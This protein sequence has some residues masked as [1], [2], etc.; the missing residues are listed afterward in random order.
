[1][2]KCEKCGKTDFDMPNGCQAPSVYSPAVGDWSCIV[3]RSKAQLQP[4]WHSPETAPRDKPFIALLDDYPWSIVAV[5]SPAM[6]K[7]A[8]A[9]IEASV[10]EG[11]DDFY[12]T[13][14]WHEVS[15]L[16]GWLDMPDLSDMC[17]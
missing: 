14:E 2:S 4:V 3:G 13:T 10:Y 17:R 1:M 6:D 5:F 15:D 16:K 7:F 12:F 9:D 11:K 8:V